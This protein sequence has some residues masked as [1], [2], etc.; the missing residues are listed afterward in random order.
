MIM[1]N[2]TNRR[3]SELA[4]LADD[5]RALMHATANVAGHKVERARNRLAHA[6]ERGMCTGEDV[7][8]ASADLAA[9]NIQEL[10]DRI[11]DALE[12]GK[13]MYEDVHE[14]VVSRTKAADHTVRENPYQAM[15]IALGVGALVGYV[16]S[17]R[18]ARNER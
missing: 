7:M 8:D 14:D 18:H 9:Q 13:E 10:R 15:G 5:A 17:F 16:L 1:R 3:S 2:K 6:L 4:G 12:H 11:S